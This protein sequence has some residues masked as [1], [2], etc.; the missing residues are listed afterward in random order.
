MLPTLIVDDM[1]VLPRLTVPFPVEDDETAFVFERACR[2]SKRLVFLVCERPVFAADASGNPASV[3]PAAFKEFFANLEREQAEN[4]GEGWIGEALADQPADYEICPVGII[5]EVGQFGP[6]AGPIPHVMLQGISRGIV[7]QVAQQEPMMICEV[8]SYEDTVPAKA[9]SEAPMAALTEQIENYVSMHPGAPEDVLTMLGGIEDPGHL[10]DLVAISP[11]FTPLQRQQV[12]EL[13]D[14]LERLRAVS[15]IVE[16]RLM[17]LSLRNAIVADAQSGM[18]KQQREYFL[19]EQ[20]RSIQKELGEGTAEETLA[21]DL[22]QRVEEAGMPDDIKAKTLDQ[23]E[24]LEQ[25]HPFSPEIGVIRSYVEWL[26]ELPWSVETEDVLDLEEAARILNEDHYGIDKVKERILEYIAVRKLAGDKLRA[27]IICFVGPPGVGKTSLGKSIARAIGRNYVRMSLGGVRDEA[28]I[29]GHRRTYVGAMPG[30]LIKAL[31]D[32]KSKNPVLV[33]D[34]ID[35]VGSDAFR[36]DPSSALLEVLDPE[37]NS[38]FSDHFLEVP[39]DLS[40]VI[41]ITTANLLEPIPPALRDRMEIIEVTGYTEAEKLAI[42][43]QYLMPKAL[44][45]HGLSEDL[46]EIT[47]AALTEIIRVYTEESGV[48]N[49]EREI[50]SVCRKAARSIA[51]Q[52]K[53]GKVRI[54]VEDLGRVLGVPRYEFGLAE[55]QDEIGVATGAA[56]TSVG[57]DLLSIEVTIMEGKGELML[58]GQLGE[59]MQE[60]GRAA[61]SYARSHAADFGIAAGFFDKHN[62]HVH[63]PAGAI[64]KDGPSAGITIATALISALTGRK[65]RKDVAMTGEMTLRGKVLPIGG[66]KEKTLAAHRGGVKT[67]ILPQRNSK[68]LAELPE[69]VKTGLKLLQVSSIE[70]VLDIALLPAQPHHLRVAESVA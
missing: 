65:V 59:I 57:G 9:L 20:I 18:D 49:L 60:S 67:F 43:K 41:F 39:F 30:R 35:K 21:K 61:I 36:G 33:L 2:G 64:P 29:R 62:I 52:K 46:L 4:T 38:T 28:E 19:R 25:Q 50:G 48:R 56:V 58:T 27:P 45:S 40:R 5:A 34:E 13:L 54:D 42:A 63:I 3:D 14:P 31:R 66:L 70:E 22:R 55:E 51:G 47:D 12:V 32:A 53:P 8:Q 6:P 16:K 11:E 1:Q 15:V 68:D 44:D 69:L 17:V 37:Q 7:L 23:L 24:R 10:A 26:I